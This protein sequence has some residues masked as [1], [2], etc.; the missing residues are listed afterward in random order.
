MERIIE[1]ELMDSYEQAEAYANADFSEP[2]SR[3]MDLFREHF[4]G[5]EIKGYI[6]DLGCGP[7]D[8]SIR[9]AKLYPE[10]I[11]HAV[12]GSEAMLHFAEEAL[13]REPP[14]ISNRIKLHLAVIP[15]QPLP[16]DRYDVIISNSLLHH[17][18]NPMVMWDTVKRYAKKGAP[19]M[20]MDLVR[21]DTEAE[22][23]KI[24]ETY[25]SAE[26][27]ILK[28]DFFNSLCAAFQ[29]QEV[30][31]QLQ[32]AGLDHLSVYQVSDRHLLVHG[33]V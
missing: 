2:N 21:P 18:H 1:P 30:K 29:I 22:A 11:V 24:V 12:D 23:R 20:I 15:S 26:P 33:F 5:A 13:R 17:L 14:E 28:R 19:L 9:F 31:A 6:L 3:F 4:K 7:A 27:E 8:I 25:A 32:E 16:L 10:C